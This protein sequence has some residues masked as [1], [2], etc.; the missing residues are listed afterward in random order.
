MSILEEHYY[1][2]RDFNSNFETL[3]LHRNDEIG[4][5][6]QK[7]GTNALASGIQGVLASQ[8]TRLDH[9]KEIICASF[10]VVVALE[11]RLQSCLVARSV[12]NFTGIVKNIHKKTVALRES[13]ML[14][15]FTES[16]A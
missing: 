8:V 16:P 3:H 6:C 15:V 9:N 12:I 14:T 13:M 10:K 1:F 4:C 2:L 7:H 5:I 11:P